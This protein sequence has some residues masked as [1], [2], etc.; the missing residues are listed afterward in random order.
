VQ[1]IARLQ[2]L[3]GLCRRS[4]LRPLSRLIDGLVRVVFAASLPGRAAIGRGVFFHHSGLGVVVNGEA[5]IGDGCEIGVHVVLGG[6]APER[7]APVLERNVIVHAGARI[8]GPVRV[9]EGCVVAANAVV[10]DSVP[11][12][13]LVAGVPAT[14]RRRG[15]DPS[16]YRRD[17][18]PHAAAEAR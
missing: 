5:V 7:G 18:R 6:R 2:R 14:I 13:C 15:I 8:I 11:A 1:V 4:G 12:G 9:G 3:S 10:L 17:A 16:A